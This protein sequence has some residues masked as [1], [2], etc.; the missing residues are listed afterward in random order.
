M[1]TKRNPN[2]A[3]GNDKKNA[4][5]DKAKKVAGKAAE[6]VGA[7][8]FGAAVTA[9]FTEAANPGD[10]DILNPELADASQNDGG[11]ENSSGKPEVKV[12]EVTNFNPNDIRIEEVI[13]TITEQ[14]TEAIE[15]EPIT[16]PAGTIDPGH[17]IAYVDVDTPHTESW[18]SPDTPEVTSSEEVTPD[19]IDILICGEPNLNPDGEPYT[20]EDDVISDIDLIS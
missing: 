19:D 3:G 14:I 15:I 13:E 18:T 16:G 1:E 11:A 8:G 7:A 4:K 9:A 20:A 12:E 5:G 17:D 10:E 6:M 2:I